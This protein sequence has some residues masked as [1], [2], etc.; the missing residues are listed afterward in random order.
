MFKGSDN[1]EGFLDHGTGIIGELRFTGRLRID[2][3]FRGSISADGILVIGEKASIHAEIKVTE[4]EIAGRVY[5][6]SDS[7]VGGP[8]SCRYAAE[9]KK[10]G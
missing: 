1:R 9:I 5:G 4:I 2:G 10:V 8:G 3:D 6:T 7:A